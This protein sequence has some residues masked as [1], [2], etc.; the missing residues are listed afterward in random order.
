MTWDSFLSLSGTQFPC[1]CGVRA[2]VTHLTSLN[3]FKMIIQASKGQESVTR[4]VF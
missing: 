4:D 3:P 1:V 2:E